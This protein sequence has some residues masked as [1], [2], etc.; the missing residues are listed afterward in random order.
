MDNRKIA[1]SQRVEQ[2]S[3]NYFPKDLFPIEAARQFLEQMNKSFGLETLVCDRH[4]GIVMV[5][6]GF[7]GFKPDVVN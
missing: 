7:E 3:K 1:F 2:N 4:G 6:G 5:N